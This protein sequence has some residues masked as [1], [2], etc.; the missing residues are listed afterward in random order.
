MCEFVNATTLLCLPAFR[1]ALATST[2]SV[3][4]TKQRLSTM[5]LMMSPFQWRTNTKSPS[6]ELQGVGLFLSLPAGQ[7]SD[8]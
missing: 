7:N 3:K 5:L 6:E 2:V 8:T 1:A 4:N